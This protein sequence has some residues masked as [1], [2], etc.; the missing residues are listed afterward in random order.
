MSMK[1]LI[2]LFIVIYLFIYLLNWSLLIS[3]KG[4]LYCIQGLFNSK[5]PTLFPVSCVCPQHMLHPKY[6]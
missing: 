1:K 4:S 3:K 2:Y 5:L 6:I